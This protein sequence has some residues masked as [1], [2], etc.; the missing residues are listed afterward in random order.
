MLVFQRIQIRGRK[1][2]SKMPSNDMKKAYELSGK[3]I[4]EKI[5]KDIPQDEKYLKKVSDS[6]VIVVRGGYDRAEDVLRAMEI[7]HVTIDPQDVDRAELNPNQVVFINCPGRLSAN[8]ISKINSFVEEGGFLIT[9]DW[10]LRHVIEPAFPG[11]LRYNQQ[12]TRDDVV[13]VEILDCGHELLEGLISEDEDPQWWLEGS[14]FPIEI[15]DKDKVE[16]LITSEEME[17]KYG[18]API[19]V[20]FNYGAGSVF[21][22]VSHYYL[23]RADLRTGRHKQ[24]AAEYF[25]TKGVAPDAAMEDV[26]LGSAESAFTSAGFVS[27]VIIEKKKQDM[28][29]KDSDRQ[30]EP[31]A[32]METLKDDGLEEKPHPSKQKAFEFAKS[33]GDKI[34]QEKGAE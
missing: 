23:Q 17:A 15:L 10:A 13:R 34:Q 25:A 30:K 12:P 22:I 7:P 26:S 16:V 18:E 1:E 8:G 6:D 5:K 19:A 31:Q 33:K 20:T 29:A 4:R 3:A 32:V 14:S 2:V 27:K 24:T 9:T 11:I 28:A 21:H